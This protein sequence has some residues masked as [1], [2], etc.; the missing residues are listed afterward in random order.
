MTPLLPV[1]RVLLALAP[2]QIFLL[3]LMAVDT[4]KLVRPRRV[5]VALA[6]G[7]A[8][9]VL[10]FAANNALLP[11]TGWPLLTFALVVAPVVEETAKGLYCDWLVRSRR[12]GFLVDATLLGFAVG[13][14]FGTAENIYYLR[15]F[16][17]PTMTTWAIRGLGTAVMH[18]GATALFAALRHLAAVLGR[19]G[20]RTWS[21]AWPA[22]VCFHALFN[23]SMTH[24]VAAT[25][26]L[27]VLLPLLLLG[28][29]R[30][31]ERNLRAWLGRGFDRDRRL[32]ELIR[33][34]RVLDSPLGRHLLSLGETVPPEARADMLC[35]LRLEAELSLAAKGMLLL[36]E[37]GFATAP[38]AEV[39][40]KLAELAWLEKSVGRA[41]RLALGEVRP[42]RGRD[43]WQRRLLAQ[44]ATD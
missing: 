28:I 13:A 40:E 43:L 24:P 2:V 22:A 18:G 25:A 1:L 30:R 31:G 29:H 37:N 19:P 23:R 15:E 34:G 17:D 39:K 4:F 7:V 16:E 21:W 5:F 8:A 14:G 6:A 32:L 36:R 33:E 41:G 12:T 3:V 44:E 35:L 9:A 42:R 10:S 26:V 20:W 11:L 27:L 38:P